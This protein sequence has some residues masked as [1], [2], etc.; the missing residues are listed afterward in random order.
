MV[1]QIFQLGVLVHFAFIYKKKL[2]LRV[3]EAVQEYFSPRGYETMR[4]EAG[5]DRFTQEQFN[6]L[7]AYLVQEATDVAFY[8]RC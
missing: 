3:K 4:A 7:C 5:A 6:R 1:H 8:S 2:R